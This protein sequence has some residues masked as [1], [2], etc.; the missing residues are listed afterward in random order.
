MVG[1]ITDYNIRKAMMDKQNIY[2]LIASQ[3][4]STCSNPFDG[5]LTIFKLPESNPH[6]N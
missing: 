4:I 5:T 3:I 1:I 2:Q 6:T